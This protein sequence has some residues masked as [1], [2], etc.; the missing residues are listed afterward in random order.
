MSAWFDDVRDSYS[1]MNNDYWG[2]DFPSDEAKQDILTHFVESEVKKFKEY[3][4]DAH[5]SGYSEMP[6]DSKNECN[7]FGISFSFIDSSTGSCECFEAQWSCN[8]AN[9]DC[10]TPE[11]I[12]DG[13][14]RVIH[15][16]NPVA[17]IDIFKQTAENFYVNGGLHR[18]KIRPLYSSEFALAIKLHCSP[19]TSSFANEWVTREDHKRGDDRYF[20]SVEDFIENAD[21]NYP[22]KTMK[23]KDWMS[24]IM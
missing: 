22:G 11:D 1:K 24:N 13:Q 12:I 2:M 17:N 18:G 8:F 15:F 20:Y 23:W 16:I 10:T 14:Y 4:P 3:F 7:Q 5:L 9:F 6:W 21:I 19:E